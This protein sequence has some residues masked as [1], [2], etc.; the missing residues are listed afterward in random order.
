MVDSGEMGNWW[1][2]M[3]RCCGLWLRCFQ[4]GRR[5]KNGVP[6]RAEAGGAPAP[7]LTYWEAA[8]R[9][10]GGGV[11]GQGAGWWWVQV[12]SAHRAGEDGG[13]CFYTGGH[14]LEPYRSD[15]I[16]ALVAYVV[17]EETWCVFPVSMF[18]RIRTIRL[19]TCFTRRLTKIPKLDKYREAWWILRGAVG[20]AAAIA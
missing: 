14:T 9:D 1:V 15:E 19:F 12:K 6:N 10:W 17:P 11:F 4:G 2:G 16:D 20:G 13:Y 3:S 18:V 7:H 8:W 5:S